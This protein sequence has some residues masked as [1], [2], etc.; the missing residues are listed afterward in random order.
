MDDL[1]R[2]QLR[3]SDADRHAVAEVLREAAGEGRIDL[4][5]LD[6]R[7]E[8]TFAARTYADL[9]PI[10][11]D[12]PAAPSGQIPARATAA[13]PSPVV[14]GPAQER[15]LAIL[16]GVDRKGVWVV[17]AH[18]TVVCFMGGAALDM[19]R[20]QFAA[21]EVVVT[22]NAIMGGADITVNPYTQVIMEGTGIMGGYAGPSDRHAPEL[23][24][25]SPVVRVRGF[26]LMG[27][28]SVSRKRVPGDA[29]GISRPGR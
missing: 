8:A 11:L 27:G 9:V 14:S 19:R 13:T 6:E 28:V 21:R 20:A 25:D 15:H 2:S 10:T 3:I 18:L 24:A 17:P 26:A 7:L 1:D 22:I 29:R 12:L 23:G 5:E 4:D 16:S